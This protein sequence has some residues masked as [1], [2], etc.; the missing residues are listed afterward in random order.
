MQLLF[1][2]IFALEKRYLS[3]LC[4]LLY[5]NRQRISCCLIMTSASLTLQSRHAS[6]FVCVR[7]WKLIDG[8]D[9]SFFLMSQ[10]SLL[11]KHKWLLWTDQQR[12]MQIIPEEGCAFSGSSPAHH[13]SFGKRTL[14]LA[15]GLVG[16]CR[17]SSKCFFYRIFLGGFL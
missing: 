13:A 5:R 4:M 8:T 12:C 7:G 15:V 3:S 2:K 6:S 11:S 17:A 16:G 1:L 9:D 10:M 14:R